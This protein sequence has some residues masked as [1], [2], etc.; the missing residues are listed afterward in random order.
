MPAQTLNRLNGPA[1]LTVGSTSFSPVHSGAHE[2]EEASE[3][4]CSQGDGGSQRSG[5]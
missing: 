4:G 2:A 3:G 1:E 5:E